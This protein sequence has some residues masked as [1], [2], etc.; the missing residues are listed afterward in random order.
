M[1]MDGMSVL[2][3]RGVTVLQY[4]LSFAY[5]VG[6]SQCAGVSRSATLN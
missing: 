2:K 1:L 5:S 4:L 3:E 6:V